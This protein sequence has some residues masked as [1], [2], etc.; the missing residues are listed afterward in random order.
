MRPADHRRGGPASA[1]RRPADCTATCWSW[2]RPEPDESPS[3]TSCSEAL[4]GEAAGRQIVVVPTDIDIA[5]AAAFGD[6]PGHRGERREPGASPWG[7]TADGG[8]HRIGGYGWQMGDEGSGYA[9]G[10]AALGGGEPRR[11]TAAARHGADRAGARASRSAD[12]DALVRWAAGARPGGVAALAAAGAGA[13][14]P[15]AIRLAQG[16]ADY[17]ARELSQLCICLLAGAWTWMPPVAVALTGGL[18]A[19][20]PAPP[21][22]ASSPELNEESGSARRSRLP[23]MR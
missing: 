23:W 12:F 15:R 7:G 8:R 17:A 4:R 5:L 21:P 18:L 13:S 2:A 9:I 6:R 14:P 22:H 11:R 16:I 3:A 1:H 10:R 19:A 20:G